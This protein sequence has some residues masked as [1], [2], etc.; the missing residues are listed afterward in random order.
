VK[1]SSDAFAQ[2]IM[3]G[4]NHVPPDSGTTPRL[5]KAAASFD[6]SA[7]MRISQPSAVSM[8][9]PAAPPFTA[10]I[11]GLSM[12][13]KTV[14][15]VLR[16]SSEVADEAEL[17]PS[18]LRSLRKSRPA[19]NA[20]PLPVRMTQRTSRSSFALISSRVRSFSIGPE[21]VFMRSGALSVMTAM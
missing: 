16:R 21:I 15:G 12:A 11:V 2:P 14:G 6:D 4:R 5:T 17:R 9:Y 8:P 13:C 3:R 7:M 1:I 18:P 20:R 19:Q 10:Q